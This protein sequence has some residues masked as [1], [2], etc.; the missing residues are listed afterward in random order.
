MIYLKNGLL[1]TICFFLY[2]PFGIAQLT[3]KGL[4]H[5]QEEAMVFV[6]PDIHIETSDGIISNQG[7]LVIEGNLEKEA[8]ATLVHPDGAGIKQVSFVGTTPVQQITGDFTATQSFYDFTMHKPEGIVQLNS[9]IEVRNF[10]NLVEGKIRTDNNSGTQAN[11]YQYELFV[12]NPAQNALSGNTSVASTDNYIEGRLRRAVAGLGNYTFPVGLTENNPFS[13][14]FNQTVPLSTISASFEAGALTPEGTAIDCNNQSSMVNSVDCAIGKWNVQGSEASYN[15]DIMLSPSE[16]LLQ[17]CP[18][19]AT[20]LVAQNGQLNCASSS[21]SGNNIRAA[22]LTSFGMFDIATTQAATVAADCPRP[23]PPVVNQLGNQKITIE[24]N[25]VSVA[26]GYIFQIRLKGM[27]NWLI[28]FPTTRNKLRIS[29]PSTTYEYRVKTVCATG[30]STYTDI[31]EF[32]IQNGNFTIAESRNANRLATDIDLFSYQ[33]PVRIYPNP[34]TEQLQVEF[35]P[36]AEAF[37][38][39]YHI[40]GKLVL[41]KQL[42]KEQDRH[43]LD[44]VS[45]ENG[46]YLLRIKEEGKQIITHRISKVGQ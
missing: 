16:S 15:Y 18:D 19:A 9:N 27:D 8:A 22:N 45:L 11:D 26:L 43:T 20:F 41:E 25:S 42:A 24:W 33:S 5:I 35:T 28:T 7:S 38:S 13:I 40:S 39:L 32:T 21:T 31:F 44:I 23:N 46:L 36:N 1:L 14:S 12:S 10:L 6:E 34:V 17:N 30:E 2:S 4:V 3:V 37:L 29:G